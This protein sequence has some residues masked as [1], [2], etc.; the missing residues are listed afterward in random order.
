MEKADR[1]EE[2]AK[3]ILACWIKSGAL[4]EKTYYSEKYRK[5]CKGLCADLSK[6]PGTHYD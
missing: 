5:D 3:R 6:L 4:K 1:S 2:Q